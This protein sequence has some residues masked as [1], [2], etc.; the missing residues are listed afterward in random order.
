MIMGD[1]CT[2]ACAFCDVKTG[3][4]KALDIFE[5]LKIAK[6]VKNLICLRNPIERAYSRYWMSAKNNF[7]LTQYS[8]QKFID[9]F[10]ADYS[11]DPDP[12]CPQDPMYGTFSVQDGYYEMLYDS[13]GTHDLS[14]SD[15]YITYPDDNTI[16]YSYQDV[17]WT[18][19]I[20]LN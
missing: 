5:P 2:R 14:E 6:D 15:I 11:N 12:D 10:Y 9:Y 13:G 1:T 8:S 18:Y 7:N 17:L 4:P 3:K 16:S 20:D 19:K